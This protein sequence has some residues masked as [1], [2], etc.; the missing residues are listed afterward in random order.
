M[1]ILLSQELLRN[2][3]HIVNESAA[4]EIDAIQLLDVIVSE[5]FEEIASDQKQE[6]ELSVFNL[7]KRKFNDPLTLQVF[8]R[9]TAL[10]DSLSMS[11]D[12]KSQLLSLMIRNLKEGSVETID[13]Q[14]LYFT[15]KI[16]FAAQKDD[17]EV[18]TKVVRL[19]MEQDVKLSTLINNA[20]V[21][22]KMFSLVNELMHFTAILLANSSPT[23]VQYFTFD[24]TE[25]I[26]VPKIFEF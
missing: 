18:S 2:C 19:L 9:V 11:S 12:D 24:P 8:Y 5:G 20:V 22:P 15:V 10:N 26:R 16:L 3:L 7:L 23:V 25:N 21:H 14:V 1:N 13:E 6:V 4:L 17:P